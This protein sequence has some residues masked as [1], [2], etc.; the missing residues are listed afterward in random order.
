MFISEGSA[1][2][3]QIKL[4]STKKAVTNATNSSGS[5]EKMSPTL[6]NILVWSVLSRKSKRC[7]SLL[8]WISRV[9]RGQRTCWKERNVAGT[10]FSVSCTSCLLA[11]PRICAKVKLSQHYVS[12]CSDLRVTDCPELS[13]QFLCHGIVFHCNALHSWCSGHQAKL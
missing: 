4:R 1:A 3:K 7:R 12:C 10:V 8:E 2:F 6:T 13:R 11:T 5:G 9:G